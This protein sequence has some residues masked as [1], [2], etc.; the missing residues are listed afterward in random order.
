MS[1]GATGTHV[2]KDEAYQTE[3]IFLGAFLMA[4]GCIMADARILPNGNRTEFMLSGP[5]TI[6]LVKE[7]S[8][9]SNN[10]LNP[11]HPFC[12]SVEFLRDTIK[13][14]KKEASRK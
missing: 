8:M 13:R 11:T 12:K 3:E 6:S 14:L 4:R 7:W 9:G 5:N 2:M 1:E 10:T